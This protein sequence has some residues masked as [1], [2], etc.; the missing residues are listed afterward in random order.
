ME[1]DGGGAEVG[2]V[3]LGGGEDPQDADRKASGRGPHL[4][5]INRQRV[6]F[7][8][9]L[10]VEEVDLAEGVVEAEDA[11][12]HVHEAREVHHEPLIRN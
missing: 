8:V 4:P 9:D 11:H 12:D 2:G 5:Q 10:G 7:A 6:G 3:G 1:Y